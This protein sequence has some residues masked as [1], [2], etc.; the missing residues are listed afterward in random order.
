MKIERQVRFFRQVMKTILLGGR[1]SV[2]L[3]VVL[4]VTSAVLEA[5]GI[6]SMMPFIAVATN[7]GVINTSQGLQVLEA[8]LGLGRSQFV[9]ALGLLFAAVT[10]I[11]NLA[12]AA[13]TV[14]LTRFSGRV[15]HTLASRL[16]RGILGRPYDY[17]LTANSAELVAVI[18]TATRRVSEGVVGPFVML[19]AKVVST[20]CVLAVLFWMDPFVAF[21]IVVMIAPI[22]GLTYYVVRDR[23]N[24]LGAQVAREDRESQKLA[25]EALSGVKDLKIL[26]RTDLVASRFEHAVRALATAQV[27]GTLLSIFPKFLIETFGVLLIVIVILASLATTREPSTAL[28]LAA[29]YAYAGY[30]LLPAVQAMFSSISTMKYNAESLEVV[31]TAIDSIGPAAEVREPTRLGRSAKALIESR[32]ELRDISFT[33]P[34]K[35]HRTLES[36]SIEVPRGAHVAIVGSSGSG[37]ST[38]LDILVGLLLPARGGTYVDGR[39]L[40]RPELAELRSRVGYVPQSVFL[41]DASIAENIAFGIPPDLID[42][43]QLRAAAQAAQI[44]E[45]IE[46]SLPEGYQTV[47][48][49]RGVRLS[50]GQRQRLGIARAIYHDPEV[51]ILDEATN[52][53]DGMTESAF[54]TTIR[55][56]AG[57]RTIVSVAHRLSS[58]RNCEWIYVCAKG[59][60][61]AAGTYD[62]LKASSPEFRALLEMRREVDVEP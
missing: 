22:Y 7:S 39:L 55:Q 47:V 30:R 9:V 24:H 35:E 11:A 8:F 56:L 17:F 14:V 6:G 45:F 26:G 5:I 48:G 31:T 13:S 43:R 2:M 20:T 12:N 58:V 19:L 37:K 18:I 21:V 27:S 46:A 1:R 53:L 60:I 34:G 25:N 10:V 38:L 50:G 42:E 28:S 57:G 62:S 33:Y 44:H 23:L 61:V 41:A 51:L 32:L 59:R 29:L 40:E 36:V 16:M 15:G 3:V 52:S 4:T 49:E 54:M